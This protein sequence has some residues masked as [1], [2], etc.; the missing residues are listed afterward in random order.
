LILLVSSLFGSIDRLIL[1]KIASAA[2]FAHYM[3]GANAG[4]RVQALGQAAMGPIFNQTNRKVSTGL[5]G[6][7]AIYNEAFNFLLPVYASICAL[8]AVWHS[9]LLRLWL[10]PEL[11]S[12]ISP[13]FT[14]LLVGFSLTALAGISGAQ[15]GSLNRLGLSLIFNL[16]AVACLAISVFVGWQ[17]GGIVGVAWGFLVSRAALIAQD[18][19][20]IRTTGAGGWLAD[21]TWKHLLFQAL[22]AGLFSVV[23]L[24]LPPSHFGLLVPAILHALILGFWILRNPLRQAVV[25]MHVALTPRSVDV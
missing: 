16:A 7:S 4:S 20:V 14:P 11:A 15:L 12:Q 3:I 25:R 1:G 22:M 23:F 19:F 10:G 2:Q 9:V 13:L 24:W 5:A 21:T 18:L 17:L 6:V 8:V